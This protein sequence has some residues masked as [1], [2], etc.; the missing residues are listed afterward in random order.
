M[1]HLLIY[2]P[3]KVKDHRIKTLIES[4]IGLVDC[5]F[6]DRTHLLMFLHNMLA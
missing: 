4:I 6:A 1:S 5:G 3:N 2:Y